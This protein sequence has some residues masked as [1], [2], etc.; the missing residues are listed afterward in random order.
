MKK[1]YLEPSMKVYEVN[2]TDGIMLQTSS[3]PVT[4]KDEGEAASR[5]DLGE[6]MGSS[7][8]STDLW[9]EGW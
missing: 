5:M 4:P 7:S 3:L 1:A 6:G 2:V 9:N 8:K